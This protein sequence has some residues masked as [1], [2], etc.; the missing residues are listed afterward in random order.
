MKTIVLLM[1]VFAFFACKGQTNNGWILKGNLEDVK[2]GWA[3]LTELAD[4]EWNILDSMKMAD[5]KFEFK[6]EAVDEIK[7]CYLQFKD[8][9]FKE[10]YVKNI[11][12]VF[13]EKGVVELSGNIEKNKFKLSGTPNNEALNDYNRVFHTVAASLYNLL[14]VDDSWRKDTVHGPYIAQG[15]YMMLAELMPKFRYLFAEKYKDLDFSLAIYQEICMMNQ[16]LKASAIDSLLNL[17]P[18]S[19]HTSPFYID[20]QKKADKIRTFEPGAVAPDFDLPSADGKMVSLSSYRGKY[21]MLV[22]WASWCGPCRAE[23]PHLM[24]IYEKYNAD[25]LDIL[26]VSVDSR[27][28]D[29][30]KAI[31]ETGMPWTQVSDLKGLR[32]AVT[33][34]YGVDGVPA[35]W[36][37]DPEGKVVAYNIRGEQLDAQLESIFGHK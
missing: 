7:Q 19:L 8:P 26:S 29:W 2:E 11:L 14:Y 27:K 18:A 21:M 20:L 4:G 9:D 23:I 10:V 37:I 16:E 13:V 3:Y 35:V 34:L 28:S 1:I 32:S 5:G 30:E 22:F 6:S 24:K 12:P 25:G 33:K 15:K 31:A 17:V 36:L